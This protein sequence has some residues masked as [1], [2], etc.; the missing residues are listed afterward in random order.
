MADK[1]KE[2]TPLRVQLSDFMPSKL[3]AIADVTEL[4]KRIGVVIEVLNSYA[5]RIDN[6]LASPVLTKTIKSNLL[7]LKNSLLDLKNFYEKRQ[8]ELT[9]DNQE[10]ID[11]T[12]DTLRSFYL[13]SAAMRLLFGI[14][15][16][17]RSSSY[18]LERL[19]L[20]ALENISKAIK[21]LSEGAVL[22]DVYTDL[23][24]TVLL[25]VNTSPLFSDSMQV[26]VA[27]KT[28]LA[29]APTI[30]MSRIVNPIVYGTYDIIEGAKE[31]FRHFRDIKYIIDQNTKTSYLVIDSSTT[32]PVRSDQLDPDKLLKKALKI[33]KYVRLSFLQS[34][35]AVQQTIAI[36]TGES[37][38][39][40]D[41]IVSDDVKEVYEYVNSILDLPA[42]IHW[43]GKER[44]E[45]AF[46]LLEGSLSA[47]RISPQQAQSINLNQYY[48]LTGDLVHSIENGYDLVT[49]VSGLLSIYPGVYINL[50]KLREIAANSYSD[51]MIGAAKNDTEITRYVLHEMKD[52]AKLPFLTDNID[53][54]LKS[55]L[56]TRSILNFY[57]SY[58]RAVDD[59][60]FL[61]SVTE[62]DT[63]VYF[64]PLFTSNE[65]TT[66][67]TNAAF[68]SFLAL[69]R[70]VD[71]V[72][73]RGIVYINT[74]AGGGTGNVGD[75]VYVS[76]IVTKSKSTADSILALANIFKTTKEITL[77]N[78]NVIRVIKAS[79]DKTAADKPGYYYFDI[80]PETE[81]MMGLLNK[82]FGS[83]KLASKIVYDD[84]LQVSKKSPFSFDMS[85]LLGGVLNL[86]PVDRSII[87]KVIQAG[88]SPIVAAFI[89]D[90]YA[91][92]EYNTRLWSDKGVILGY[93][94]ILDIVPSS[95]V[96]KE[97]LEELYKKYVYSVISQRYKIDVPD[98]RI[99]NVNFLQS[100]F[101]DYKLGSILNSIAT[102]ILNSKNEGEFFGNI[103]KLEEKYS[104]S[105]YKYLFDMVMA[106]IRRAMSVA[107]T[108]SFS[109]SVPSHAANVIHLVLSFDIGKLSRDYQNNKISS[110]AYLTILKA[111]FQHLFSG[112]TLDG[113]HYRQ[114]LGE[115]FGVTSILDVVGGIDG[116]D[117]VI[118]ILCR[119]KLPSLKRVGEVSLEEYLAEAYEGRIELEE[120]GGGP[121]GG[122]VE[123]VEEVAEEYTSQRIQN[124]F[125]TFT[126]LKPVLVV[127]KG[128]NVIE[129][130][131]KRNTAV[132][133]SNN[134]KLSHESK[135]GNIY[136]ADGVVLMVFDYSNIPMTD[137]NAA[138]P[139]FITEEA[140]KVL[141]NIVPR[142]E[143][144]DE[145]KA[146]EE[147][148][149]AKRVFGKPG[150]SFF[151]VVLTLDP[152]RTSDNQV[153]AAPLA[154][155]VIGKDVLGPFMV[156]YGTTREDIEKA[157]LELLG[158]S[159]VTTP[160]DVIKNQITLYFRSKAR[161]ALKSFIR[162]KL[163]G[164][165]K[166]NSWLRSAAPASQNYLLVGSSIL[167]H[168]EAVD[169]LQSRFEEWLAEKQ[170]DLFE[171]L[172]RYLG[173][174][175]KVG[176][177]RKVAS[178]LDDV[179]IRALLEEIGF[180]LSKLAEI[181]EIATR[182]T[183]LAREINEV[184]ER[185]IKEWAKSEFKIP[186]YWNHVFSFV[187]SYRRAPEATAGD[188][189]R[190]RDRLES[191]KNNITSLW[192]SYSLKQRLRI[193]V[194]AILADYAEGGKD[195]AATVRDLADTATLVKDFVNA[196]SLA[197]ASVVEASELIA[198]L[199]MCTSIP[200]S[201][202][203]TVGAEKLG[204]PA[205]SSFPLAAF[206]RE[207]I[208][209]CA[210]AIRQL[211]QE[212]DEVVKFSGV[213]VDVSILEKAKE[214]AMSQN[215]T[216]I[217]EFIEN[218]E[219][220]LAVGSIT[221]FPVVVAPATTPTQQPTLVKLTPQKPISEFGV[222]QHFKDKT[223]I[224]SDNLKVPETA[225]LYPLVYSCSIC[226]RQYPIDKL[227]VAESGERLST[228]L[229]DYLFEKLPESVHYVVDLSNV[230]IDRS[231]EGLLNPRG[232]ITLRYLPSPI[233]LDK[234][235]AK[236]FIRSYILDQFDSS[237]NI[238][239]TIDD[240]IMRTSEV[241]S[242]LFLRNIDSAELLLTA[243]Y[244]LCALSEKV[245]VMAVCPHCGAKGLTGK[246][247]VSIPTE[248]SFNVE[249]IIDNLY[250]RIDPLLKSAVLD[251]FMI[252]KYEDP[253][254][255]A[256]TPVA[257]RTFV[258][259]QLNEKEIS[260][261][262][263]S[264]IDFVKDK[265]I[266][267][268]KYTFV[269]QVV[270]GQY[271]LEPNEKLVEYYS[272]VAHVPKEEARRRLTHSYL[273]RRRLTIS[274]DAIQVTFN[275]ELSLVLAPDDVV[276]KFI[277]T[278]SALITVEKTQ[279]VEGIVAR[280]P[281][282]LY[283]IT[284]VDTDF[285]KLGTDTTEINI[286]IFKRFKHGDNYMLY[287]ISPV[288]KVPYDPQNMVGRLGS[289][290]IGEIHNDAVIN[291]A[292]RAVIEINAQSISYIID[293]QKLHQYI[294]K[295]IADPNYKIKLE[296]GYFRHQPYEH[297]ESFYRLYT[298]NIMPIFI[299]SLTRRIEFTMSNTLASN[300]LIPISNYT[301][302]PASEY[303]A[304]TILSFI[305]DQL[306]NK[307]TTQT[308]QD[309]LE[310][311]SKN[312]TF[313]VAFISSLTKDVIIDNIL[314]YLENNKAIQS[315]T[316]DKRK[317]A[318]LVKSTISAY[319]S[320]YAN[321]AWNPLVENDPDVTFGA[322]LEIDVS[323]LLR[324]FEALLS[325][326]G[327]QNLIVR[328]PVKTRITEKWINVR[329]AVSKVQDDQQTSDDAYV[330]I[331]IGS[332]T[333]QK[334]SQVKEEAEA[335]KNV[336][337]QKDRTAVPILKFL[338]IWQY[339]DT[340]WDDIIVLDRDACKNHL[341]E[342]A[343]IL[344]AYAAR[345]ALGI[346]GVYEN[347]YKVHI[348]VKGADL[349]NLNLDL[350][351]TTYII[352]NSKTM[353]SYLSKDE[354][355]LS[356]NIAVVKDIA[357][358]ILGA[359]YDRYKKEVFFTRRSFTEP[360][361]NLDIY[362]TFKSGVSTV[363]KITEQEI[364]NAVRNVQNNE[365]AALMKLNPYAMNI[366]Y[367]YSWKLGDQLSAAPKTKTKSFPA[368]VVPSTDRFASL[369]S[370][371]TIVALE[372]LADVISEIKQ[373]VPDLKVLRDFIF[374]V[375]IHTP[376]SRFKNY[377]TRMI[378]V[379]PL[380]VPSGTKNPAPDI[381]A[382][383][384]RQAL[385][386]R[387]KHKSVFDLVKD[388]YALYG[389]IIANRVSD[390]LGEIV[391][392][393]RVIDI[394]EISTDNVIGDLKEQIE[395]AKEEEIAEQP[396]EEEKPEPLIE[397]PVIP[398]EQETPEKPEVTEGEEEEVV[399]R[400]PTEEYNGVVRSTNDRYVVG[401]FPLSPDHVV[402]RLDLKDNKMVITLGA[403]IAEAS[404][405]EFINGLKN[406][407]S[408]TTNPNLQTIC[409]ELYIVSETA[410]E[411][412]I[413][414]KH[415]EIYD[416]LLGAL[417]FMRSRQGQLT[418]PGLVTAANP[419]VQLFG[420]LLGIYYKVLIKEA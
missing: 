26:T 354:V 333:G 364:R 146:L 152:D 24:S 60:S 124:L 278:K 332:D 392:I 359:E 334:A 97:K 57:S 418:I 304:E 190:I 366:V 258:R 362:I 305:K 165:L 72:Y 64:V 193:A 413:E 349:P 28:P 66:I 79:I 291:S 265:I 263:K 400:V 137:S 116:L 417:L 316:F 50:T 233:S 384:L 211:V 391:S 53:V 164:L 394:P 199:A 231:R 45:Q 42:T 117:S 350:P 87:E 95:E 92:N 303:I 275:T 257:H 226:Q 308:V 346:A 408:V 255:P 203:F 262:G 158:S 311:L 123:E 396:V 321:L 16:N 328:V 225:K 14:L 200:M 7:N 180:R 357:G 310:E 32:Q 309:L 348:D 287:G 218:V 344:V 142:Y 248:E 280:I 281:Q 404:L 220:L 331:M 375:K 259:I 38:N 293:P 139:L 301:A 185:I 279:P 210:T 111:I 55:G 155:V 76:G 78:G 266:E 277:K 302:I 241:V 176:S 420:V 314:K 208:Q 143:D 228:T 136:H 324:E 23:G 150:E 297:I 8:N 43:T 177:R 5:T 188:F 163:F 39:L 322:F 74:G 138:K 181:T 161:S 380:F 415:Y 202:S 110:F 19:V 232:T 387:N 343:H 405:N 398:Q 122:A 381:Y 94:V 22:L 41:Y 37:I 369:E 11:K 140:K 341:I 246:T 216:D 20:T 373:A 130:K 245:S 401:K 35:S 374:L 407:Q 195:S 252:I 183:V 83:R 147:K 48:D 25:S 300:P 414:A 151:T 298:D 107:S 144:T 29:Y 269:P 77:P 307:S 192:E 214:R 212:I 323:D 96:T 276:T 264:L 378:G 351:S 318:D 270:C 402:L 388:I 84:I 230:R 4:V 69:L 126:E 172:E 229:F 9:P 412:L 160:P 399:R 30:I 198:D 59:D 68:L 65:V 15:R 6:A 289:A 377:W 406:P 234:N 355:V 419:Y 340:N 294:E 268:I 191:L 240:A 133:W 345:K 157:V 52:V 367:E 63:G 365:I 112:L 363:R 274:P 249:V 88:Y 2:R 283:D 145:Q 182:V 98:H 282:I 61:H 393:K 347:L 235:W 313:R 99:T 254:S 186:Q 103:V 131:D 70:M 125:R 201:P 104:D 247:V 129:I 207:T 114:G 329:V 238:Q 75:T 250:K 319:V 100:I 156:E 194:E 219:S 31:F 18:K 338:K 358:T 12:K 148:A 244:Y 178:I 81:G 3:K 62:I 390:A 168:T 215:D 17:K 205:Y 51:T 47:F 288:K 159:N 253:F 242:Y 187:S 49:V 330:S 356:N 352:Q 153:A 416:S 58:G 213:K 397:E 224:Y 89:T 337:K 306:N 13:F 243:Y 204:N 171:I 113:I 167:T 174:R 383:L 90:V 236:F 261:S 410:K 93:P 108:L 342:L 336:D 273:D 132:Y 115:I 403:V 395:P 127:D 222:Q 237:T 34:L 206:D 184:I 272:E 10:L 1:K 227:L 361:L 82:Y 121:E 106:L 296:S 102:T 67:S 154:I 360:Y 271:G 120:E 54:L 325:D 86:S 40:T 379:T 327:R 36:T 46:D 56:P 162:A 389:W 179:G 317:F 105:R 260:G 315:Q 335:K 295:K 175:P 170:I 368:V 73:S 286:V 189:W 197:V 284:T 371:F 135:A 223:I 267:Y 411:I 382:W 169:V 251:I 326:Y 118:D 166:T 101:E 141:S 196:V 209:S 339:R 292:R 85:Y 285:A 128:T 353:E 119:A 290:I 312:E 299:D 134:L 386:V 221:E 239:K 33:S 80:I 21:V 376:I 149:K 385:A 91:V 27:T 217:L 173:L 71:D 372:A 370:Y 256:K 109:L 409:T 320:K 44:I